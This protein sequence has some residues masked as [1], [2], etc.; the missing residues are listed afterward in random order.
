V[1]ATA[2]DGV[3]LEHAQAG[4]GLAGV[5]DTR[6]GALDRLDEGAS[7]CGDAREALQE[8]QGDAFG[9]DDGCERALDFREVGAGGD[10]L[11]ICDECLDVDFLFDVVYRLLF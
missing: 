1:A 5:E 8:V 7:G 4:R 3:A 6:L 11:A 10:A 9:G 2:A